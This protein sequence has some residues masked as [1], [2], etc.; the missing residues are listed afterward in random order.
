MQNTCKWRV[1]LLRCHFFVDVWVVQ[2]GAEHHEAEGEDVQRVVPSD[3]GKVWVLRPIRRGKCLDDAVNALGLARQPERTDERLQCAIQRQPLHCKLPDERRQDPRL[4]CGG[5]SQVL[6]KGLRAQFGG[7]QYL[8]HL[9]RGRSVSEH[10]RRRR[11]RKAGQ[12]GD[13]VEE[14]EQEGERG[15][16]GMAEGTEGVMDGIGLNGAIL[17]G[18][19]GPHSDCPPASLSPASMRGTLRQSR[20]VGTIGPN[21]KRRFGQK[22]RAI[23]TCGND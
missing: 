12:Q 14:Q 5:R 1:H 13:V 19:T 3:A 23:Q 15:E 16:Q 4:L 6:P 17:L 18:S 9:R 22:K 7:E 8:G 11:R 21:K 10:G 2:V 20:K